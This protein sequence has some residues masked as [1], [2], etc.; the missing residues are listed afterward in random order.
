MSDVMDGFT[1]PMTVGRRKQ[2]WCIFVS[3]A[4]H[5][6][7]LAFLLASSLAVPQQPL[8]VVLVDFS[9]IKG[10]RPVGPGPKA[11]A[12]ETRPKQGIAGRE[13]A[14]PEPAVQ[15]HPAEGARE[16]ARGAER[17]EPS[18]VPSA[19]AAPES[20][21]EVS[22]SPATVSPLAL[23][24]EGDSVHPQEGKGPVVVSAAR[25]LGLPASLLDSVGSPGAMKGG[26][27]AGAQGEASWMEGGEDYNFIRDEILK[28]VRYP[29]QARRLGLEGR[30]LLSFVVLENGTVS[31]VRVVQSSDYRLLDEAAKEAV[32]TTR[33]TKPLPC[34]VIVRLPITYRLQGAREGRL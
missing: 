3:I 13:M 6:A 21:S 17:Q 18:F 32:A 27:G 14:A 5:L 24:S 12:K 9:Q 34:R 2:G 4:M 26:A 20:R 1:G 33:V 19:I 22:G 10:Q 29:D 7:V 31:E 23:P 28:K 30:V 11:E 16:T 25:P 8:Q 15:P